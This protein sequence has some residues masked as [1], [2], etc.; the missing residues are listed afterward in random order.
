M[1]SQE[2][3]AEQVSKRRAQLFGGVLFE[4]E[5]LE[6]KSEHHG[7]HT[8]VRRKSPQGPLEVPSAVATLCVHYPEPHPALPPLSQQTHTTQQPENPLARSSPLGQQELV[9]HSFGRYGPISLLPECS[10]FVITASGETQ[11]HTC[12]HKSPAGGIF[13]Q[14][15]RCP[16]LSRVRPLRGAAHSPHTTP[17]IFQAAKAAGGQGSGVS[18][19]WPE[20][21]TRRLVRSVPPAQVY[22]P[23]RHWPST[24]FIPW[25]RGPFL[26]W[27]L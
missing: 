26:S 14:L 9:C 3:R 23:N 2:W 25:G 8:A 16:A 11:A 6:G 21:P 10:S 12:G 18:V 13:P 4:G 15:I 5:H 24:A 1:L 20:R 27:K 7:V 17:G 19:C 22:R